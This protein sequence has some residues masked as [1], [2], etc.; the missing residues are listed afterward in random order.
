MSSHLLSTYAS[1][2]R[3]WNARINLVAPGTLDV[4]ET[5]HIAD[6]EQLKADMPEHPVSIL[7][8]GSGAGL[9]GLVLA[10]EAP[11]HRY[12]LCESDQRKAAFLMTAVQALGLKNVT[13]KPCRVEQLETSELFAVITCRAFAPLP[14][15]LPQTRHLLAADG[16]WLLLKGEAVDEELKACETLMPLAIQR[17]PSR[18]QGKGGARGWV[19]KLVPGCETPR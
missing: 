4:L 17:R 9:P 8:V 1:L 15:L 13:V 18:V 16:C 12:T 19:L 3:Q 14:R 10:I 11:Q 6:C 7:D 5:R 2:L